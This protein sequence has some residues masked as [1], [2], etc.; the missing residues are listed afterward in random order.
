MQFQNVFVRMRLRW[1][2]TAVVAPALLCVLPAMAAVSVSNVPLSKPNNVPGNL[3]LVPSVEW[4][5][6]VTQAN[7]PGVNE[8]SANYSTTATTTCP[9]GYTLNSGT[10]Q[11]SV[12][13]TGN[14]A[15]GF[16]L[17]GGSC[18]ASTSP[19]SSTTYSC[20]TNYSP[21]SG[22]TSST[23]CTRRT[24][25]SC[26]SGYSAS[27]SGSNRTCSGPPI[28]TTAYS[29]PSGYS[30]T[31][32]V[33]A[34][35]TCTRTGSNPTYSCPT[36]TASGSG[37]S[38]ICIVAT[39]TPT[40]AFSPY[41]GYFNPSL[42]YAYHYDPVEANRY[43]YPVSQTTTVSGNAFQCAGQT[44][45]TP[46]Q[47]LWSGNYL[48]WVSMQA[49]D[50]FRLALTGGYRVHRPADGT[51]PT[52]T[53]TVATANGYTTV[54]KATSEMPDVTYLEKANADRWD[55]SYVKLRRIVAG[56]DAA[57]ATPAAAT[58]SGFRARIGA[59]RNQMWFAPNVNQAMGSGRAFNDPRALALP[60][61]N[62]AQDEPGGATGTGFP[63]VPY[64]PAYH[65]LPNAD[66]STAV[67]SAA[68]GVNEPGCEPTTPLCSSGTSWNGSACTGQTTSSSSTTELL[69]TNAT[70]P[71]FYSSG[72]TR[73]CQR[74]SSNTSNIAFN[75]ACANSTSGNTVTQVTFPSSGSNRS[76]TL[77][78]TTTTTIT[79][80]ATPQYL[81][82]TYGR[83][84]VYAVSVRVKVC[85]GTLDTRDF[86]TAYGNNYKPEGLLQKNA[87][88]VRY[89]LFSYLTETG[90]QRQ[91]GVMRARQKFIG[92]IG[93]EEQAGIEKPYPDRSRIVGIDNPEWDPVTGVFINN[94][95]STDASATTTNVGSCGT[96]LPPDGSNCQIQYSGVI[97]YLNRFGQILTGQPTLKSY[98]NLTEM[99]YTALRYLR[100]LVNISSFSNL[101][102][103]SSG[104]DLSASGALAKYQ[105][106][107]GLPVIDDWYKTGANTA[108]TQWNASTP[109]RTTGTD[110]DPMLY[111]CQTTVVLGIGDTS[112]QSEDDQTDRSKD[113]G[114]PADTWRGYTEYT[115][116][117]GG[118]GN[119]AGLAYWAHVN[120]IRDDIPNMDIIN[121]TPGSKRGQTISTY[122]V[123]VVERNDLFAKNTNQYY[124]AT[125]YGGYIIPDDDWGSDG[126]A[127]RRNTSWFDSNKGLWSAATQTVKTATGLGGTGDYYLPDNMYL[128]NNGQKMIDGLNSAFQKIS[129][130]LAG[131]GASLAANSTR[132]DTGTTTYQAVYFSRD[133][134][135]DLKAFAVNSNG[136]IAATPT[137][138]AS[139]RLPAAASRN[140]K[141]CTGDCD[142]AAHLV[143][144]STTTTFDSKNDL[145]ANSASCASG[146]ANAKIEYL[147]GSAANER[148]NGGTLRSRTSVLGDIIN[149]Q[150]VFVGA[151][152][153][154]L[155]ANRTFAA[156]YATFANTNSVRTR[157]KMIYVA[158]N[159]GMLHGFNAEATTVSGV[160]PGQEVF[161][162]MP[163]AVI[164]NGIKN[165]ALPNYGA[166]ENPHQFYNDGELAVADVKIGSSWKTVLVGTTGRGLAKAVY[167]LDVTDPANVALLWERSAGDGQLNAD[168][169]GQVVG[170][171][172]I[173]RIATASGAKWVALIGNGYN[174]AND[175]PAL[176]QFDLAT[177]ALSVYTTTGSSDDDGLSPPAA[178]ISDATVNTNISTQAYAGDLNGNVWEFDLDENGGAGTRL[179]AA[180]DASG[181]PQPITGG[182]MVSKK[183][184]DNSVWAFFGTGSFLST[185]GT[186]DGRQTWYGLIVQGEDKVNA[187]HTRSDLR[188]RRIMAESPGTDTRLAARGI[189]AAVDG[190]MEGKKGWFIDLLSP[191]NPPGTAKGERMVTPNQFQ[192]SLLIGTSRVPTTNTDPCN[193]SGAGWIMA[194]DPFL[195]SPPTSP[196][197]DVNDDGRFTTTV[198]GDVV[199][200]ADGN[201][202]VAAG[203]GFGSIPNNPIFVGHTM[204]VS[205]DD[206]TTGTVNTRGTIGEV[207]RLSWREVVGQ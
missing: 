148:R 33:T 56:S 60:I 2:R 57:G 38:M 87:S 67:S 127:T 100:G 154:N 160:Q 21:T 55:D 35:T 44:G 91:G 64:D 135:G 184:A 5:T 166:Q 119:V 32:G 107:D 72:S 45:G 199:T 121:R 167:A 12:P 94:P 149:S 145:C 18:V 139:N 36:G 128:A 203:V 89:S 159:D 188:Q 54:S 11:L 202:Y 99:Y 41:A 196:F 185:F 132:L 189:S 14:C 68:C 206:A 177:G 161:A 62:G 171:P 76:C 39:A 181:N 96:T 138:Q 82:T 93:A 17:S 26:Y 198:N 84:Q 110:G 66:T 52:V 157:R 63:A 124:N 40:T 153:A 116:G 20:P 169:I 136:S 16:E 151:P 24:T 13:A 42:C 79:G 53:M 179:F 141:T 142:E 97:N 155:Y 75:S 144:F 15:A 172:V 78:S 146:E 69:C 193:P 8:G 130:D 140:I 197:F 1:L 9:S 129:E 170:K 113:S 187:S 201:T 131:S 23:T 101:T 95:D 73:R 47:K 59:L 117:G 108:V 74:S 163:K 200:D 115:S 176:L 111:Q 25:S 49:I 98:D 190:D 81:H 168:H 182:L 162:Y 48:N 156:E 46:T 80:T 90:Q 28:A 105:N 85:D 30:P 134:R 34:S 104:S 207:R 83:N 180:T 106:T 194:L 58:N 123:D 192:G 65:T 6:V 92:P 183:K 118:R 191:P 178:W 103:A 37:S 165:I 143:N 22:V 86:C 122:W 71:Y 27:G 186:D 29:C 3:V 114:A 7:D 43:F 126:N 125:K 137:W 61:T 4:P 150:P 173:A 205:F 158:A 152:N 175:R 112:T 120:D 109:A 164:K 50:T 174:S 88:R 19:N 102:K 147:R 31:S 204:L 77:T 195:G 133:W 10:C 70:Y 51:P